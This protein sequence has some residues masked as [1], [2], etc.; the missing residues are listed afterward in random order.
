VTLLSLSLAA[1]PD[2]GGSLVELTPLYREPFL[3]FGTVGVETILAIVLLSTRALCF[4]VGFLGVR[5]SL[6]L[7]NEIFRL[8]Q[9]MFG[10]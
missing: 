8:Y 10:F 5:A 1:A 2:T 6:A 9:L 3:F 4:C 7:P